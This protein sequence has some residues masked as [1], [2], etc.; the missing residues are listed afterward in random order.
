M[1][2]NTFCRCDEMIS[3]YHI[4]VCCIANVVTATTQVSG[5]QHVCNKINLPS[6]VLLSVIPLLHHL[7]SLY[8][9]HKICEC[10]QGVTD[11]NN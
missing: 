11:A 5:K 4:N 7:S 2:K 6:I 9:M 3:I 8:Y 10:N 1:T